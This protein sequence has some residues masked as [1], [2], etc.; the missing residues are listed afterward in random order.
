WSAGNGLGVQAVRLSG[1]A[2]PAVD[3]RGADAEDAGHGGRGFSLLDQFDGAA[4]AAFEF[5]RCSFGS[6]T[7][8]YACPA[9]S[10]SFFLLESVGSS[11]SS[12]GITCPFFA[13]SILPPS[14]G[15]REFGGADRRCYFPSPRPLLTEAMAIVPGKLREVSVVLML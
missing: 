11:P 9:E 1:Q 5:S 2:S 12:P 14:P 3:G 6:H 8:L 13:E 4:T 7:S 10:V 15:P